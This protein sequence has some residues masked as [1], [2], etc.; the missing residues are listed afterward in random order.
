MIYHTNPTST[1]TIYSGLV[2]FDKK[3]EEEKE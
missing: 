3:I 1:M 2:R